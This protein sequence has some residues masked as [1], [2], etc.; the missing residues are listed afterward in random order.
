ML[1]AALRALRVSGAS[2]RACL[3]R[4]T[5]KASAPSAQV[6]AAAA[7]LHSPGSSSGT[8][9]RRSSTGGCGY[10]RMLSLTHRMQYLSAM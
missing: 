8:M 1:A 7:P 6:T 2:Q 3:P 4:W 5:R 9:A 10:S